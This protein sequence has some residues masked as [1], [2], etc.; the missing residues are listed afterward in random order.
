VFA[1][2]F[3]PQIKTLFTFIG[4]MKSGWALSMDAMK[5]LI[6]KPLIGK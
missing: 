3:T 6:G 4:Q 1:D 5:L 2:N